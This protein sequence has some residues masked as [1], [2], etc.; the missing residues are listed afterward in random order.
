MRPNDLVNGGAVARG[1]TAT[2]ANTKLIQAFGQGGDDI[3]TLNE[4]SGALPAASL[5][6]SAGNDTITGGSGGDMLVGQAATSC[7]ARVAMTSFGGGE[8]AGGDGDDQMFSESGDDHMIWNRRR[9]RPHGRRRRQRYRGGERRQRRRCSPPLRMHA[10]TVRRLSPAPFFLD[11]GTTENL[12]LNMNG[13]DTF[14][15][16]GNLAT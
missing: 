4:S 16:T 11:I 14:S 9:Q 8:N 5:F 13:D 3:I 2:V 6:G 7:S 1:R 10:R 12:V 15:A